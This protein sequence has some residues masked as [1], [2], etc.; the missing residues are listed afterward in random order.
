MELTWEFNIIDFFIIFGAVIFLILFVVVKYITDKDKYP[1]G[2]DKK[3]V[4]DKW[5]KIEDL[6]SYGKEMNFKL[7]VI[8]ADKLLDYVLKESYFQGETMGDRLK[9]ATYRYPKLRQVW[10][11]HKV[12]NHVV[13][14]TKYEL[15]HGEAKK[16]LG[17]FK[18]ALKEL[19]AI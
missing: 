4:R 3:F 8:E 5:R 11:A 17:L 2:I 6:F 15:R 7:A 16:V 19:K 10:W 13:H 18:N 14:E 1:E 9:M 12:R